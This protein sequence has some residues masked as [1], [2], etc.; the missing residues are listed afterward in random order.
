MLAQILKC[1][2]EVGNEVVYVLDADAEAEHV[3]V[4]ACR[5]LLLRTELRMGCRCRV[6]DER[7]RV[8]YA[9]HMEDELQTGHERC[10]CLEASLHAEC[11]HATETMLEILLS[12]FMVL[13]ALQTRVVHALDSR[14][15][16]SNAQ[17]AKTE[18]Q[19]PGA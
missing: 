2:G 14:V 7:L 17:L 11:E 6:Y 15:L 4:N 18:S 5:Y 8:S 10:S 3:R 9:A 13:V 16:L 1:S 12:E 19:D